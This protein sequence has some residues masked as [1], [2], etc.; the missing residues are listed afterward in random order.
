MTQLARYAYVAV[1]WLYLVGL[2]TQVYLAGMGL[3]GATPT[4]ELHR[5]VGYL[6]HLLTLLVIITALVARI[7]RPAIW[8]V[9]A[10]TV[11][12]LA[13]PLLP[14]MRAVT[15]WVAALHP[16]LAVVLVVLAVKLA[17]DGRS[18]LG[19]APSTEA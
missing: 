9:V 19:A 18:M 2:L 8:W 14:S 4:L 16:L 15:P 10:L 11:I 6:V 17:L 12:G 5:N 1:I 3:F 13:Q 7:G